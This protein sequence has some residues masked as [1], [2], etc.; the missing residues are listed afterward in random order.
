MMLKATVVLLVALVAS[1]QAQ[2]EPNCASDRHVI[3]HLFEWKWKDIAA[4][5]E[6]FLGPNNFCGVQVGSKNCIY[7]TT[8][9]DLCMYSGWQG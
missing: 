8:Q 7:V 4:E 3:V 5:C 2:W 1:V 9:I 6:R